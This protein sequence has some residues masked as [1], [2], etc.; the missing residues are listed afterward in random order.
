MPALRRLHL[1]GAFED[2]VGGPPPPQQPH[3]RPHRALFPELKELVVAGC[4]A[5]AEQLGW[6]AWA[7]RLEDLDASANSLDAPPPVHPS[8]RLVRLDLSWNS[9]GFD[10]LSILGAPQ[11]PPGAH[12]AADSLVWLDVSNNEILDYGAVE[13]LSKLGRG[14]AAPAIR[15]VCLDRNGLSASGVRWVEREAAARLAP[16]GAVLTAWMPPSRV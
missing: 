16:H 3:P 8:A 6:V 5:S 4:N 15:T 7:P 9:L 10:S 11:R 13:L 2:D 1:C 12:I 14:R